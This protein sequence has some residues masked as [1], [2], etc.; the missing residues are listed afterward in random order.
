MHRYEYICKLDIK[1]RIR[2]NWFLEL[3][4]KLKRIL[5]SQ[6]SPSYPTKFFF[7]FMSSVFYRVHYISLEISP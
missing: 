4:A 5:V 3:Y 1:Y 2:L 6:Y 7:N